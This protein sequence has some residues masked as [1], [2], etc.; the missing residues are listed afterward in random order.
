MSATNNYII[1]EES[2]NL[3]DDASTEETQKGNPDVFG[4]ALE[5]QGI[6]IEGPDDTGELG[7]SPE[8]FSQALRDIDNIEI[9]SSEEGREN[10][11]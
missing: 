3:G 2:Q 7:E 11:D 5:G 8:D 10:L 4:E 6:V 9:V 1:V